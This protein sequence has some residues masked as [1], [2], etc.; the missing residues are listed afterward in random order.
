MEEP[1]RAAPDAP[2]PA[3]VH[4]RLEAAELVKKGLHIEG[5]AVELEVGP[6]AFDRRGL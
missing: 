4:G 3:T 6:D 1:S 2:Q 5:A